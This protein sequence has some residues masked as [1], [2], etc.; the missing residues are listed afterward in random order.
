MCFRARGKAPGQGTPTLRTSSQP[1]ANATLSASQPGVS[2]PAVQTTVISWLSLPLPLPRRCC[3]C[4]RRCPCQSPRCMHIAIHGLLRAGIEDSVVIWARNLPVGG[5]CGT[6]AAVARLV[7]RPV[8]MVI[9]RRPLL[10][11]AESLAAGLAPQQSKQQEWNITCTIRPQLLQQAGKCSIN[12][13]GD[14]LHRPPMPVFQHSLHSPSA[15]S[16]T[17]VPISSQ[18]TSGELW[19]ENRVRRPAPCMLMRRDGRAAPVCRLQLPLC[20]TFS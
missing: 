19:Q 10:L 16:F 9:Q 11:A 3:R 17:S 18:E 4:C 5:T 12:K 6:P 2:Q 14:L 7:N 20:R 8:Q 15:S 1:S 13:T